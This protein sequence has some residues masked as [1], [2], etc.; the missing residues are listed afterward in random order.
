[1]LRQPGQRLPRTAGPLAGAADA[2]GKGKRP[3]AGPFPAEGI[4]REGIRSTGPGGSPAD[5]LHAG[6]VTFTST[7]HGRGDMVR[8]RMVRF[9]EEA[10]RVETGIAF[11]DALAPGVRL[12]GP[13][14]VEQD[15]TTTLVPPGWQALTKENGAM[16]LFPEKRVRDR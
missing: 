11:R 8:R 6:E 3:P 14:I 2:A 4:A 15:D 16:V 7:G 12:S 10:S 9:P 1:M 13:A 5:G